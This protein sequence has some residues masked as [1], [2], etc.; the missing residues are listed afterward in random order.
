[1]KN[2]AHHKRQHNKQ[3]PPRLRHPRLAPLQFNQTTA[4]ISSAVTRLMF[5]LCCRRLGIYLSVKYSRNSR[6]PSPGCATEKFFPPFCMLFRQIPHNRDRSRNQLLPPPKPVVR[7]SEH[8]TGPQSD[9]LAC[10][11]DQSIGS[12][13]C[14]LSCNAVHKPS[15]HL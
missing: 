7:N 6:P 4:P 2:D 1:M 10:A 3:Y 15:F 13:R 14:Y 11:A 12:A 5:W 9:S 8:L